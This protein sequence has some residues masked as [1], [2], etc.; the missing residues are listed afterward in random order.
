MFQRFM[1]SGRLERLIEEFLDDEEDG[2]VLQFHDI[3]GGPNSF[4]L[5]TKFCYGVKVELIA[6]NVVIL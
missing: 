2:C 3:P 5:A 1:H 4:E 6:T